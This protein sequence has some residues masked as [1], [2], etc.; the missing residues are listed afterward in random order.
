MDLTSLLTEQLKKQAIGQISQK[1]G[2]DAGMTSA[3]IG[4]AL[5]MILGGLEKNTQTEAGATALDNALS[6]HDGK[7]LSNIGEIDMMDGSKI[8]GHILWD[9]GAA[10]SSLAQETGASKE[11][12]Q[13]VMNMLGP[14]VM[15]A[16][17]KEKASAGLGASDITKLLSGSSKSSN[18][19]G[20]FLDQD[21]DGDFDKSDA[22]K[23]GMDWMKNKFMWK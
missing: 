14:I 6:K 23:F 3:L 22:M 21:G 16:L 13:G 12:S 20:M 1:V 8:L 9:S 19:L 18:M 15:G 10:A 4:K 7:A 2:G 17:W 11:Q 5:P